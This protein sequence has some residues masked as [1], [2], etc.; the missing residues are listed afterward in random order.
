MLRAIIRLQ[1]RRVEARVQASHH[2]PFTF[3]DDVVGLI[4]RR[5]TQLDSGGR[6]I[7]AILTNSLLPRISTEV[8]SRV[9]D[10][11]TIAGVHV[12]AQDEEFTYVFD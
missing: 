2:V 5:C 9:L 4:A 10:G 1:L 7:D 3:D 8:L 11:R 12:T 6:M